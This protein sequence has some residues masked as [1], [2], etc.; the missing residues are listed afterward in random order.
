M[1]LSPIIS[2]LGVVVT[3]KYYAGYSS[4]PIAV[5][6]R[7]ILNLNVF[8]LVVFRHREND[9]IGYNKHSTTAVNH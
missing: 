1:I 6:P 4:N 5:K 9:R 7:S 8:E 2:P 3:P